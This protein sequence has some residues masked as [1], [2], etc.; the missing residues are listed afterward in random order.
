MFKKLFETHPLVQFGDGGFPLL[1]YFPQILPG[2][3]LHPKKSGRHQM[4]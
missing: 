1:S 4:G 2:E 3:P